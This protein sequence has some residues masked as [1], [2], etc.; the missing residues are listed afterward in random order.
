MNQTLN[1]ICRQLRL[2]YVNE[3]VAEK[4]SV[5]LEALVREVL[6][7]ELAG[8]QRAKLH[9]LLK[10][11]SFPQFKTFDDYSFDTVVFPADYGKERLLRLDWLKQKEN[12]LML[13]AV[14]TGK[15][16]LAIALGIEAA[17][18]GKLVRFFRVADLVNALQLKHDDGTL[19]KF[20]RGLAKADLII[21]DEL[22]YVPFHRTGSELLFNIVTACYEHQS[23][24]VTS[25]L[26]FSQWCTIFGDAKLT[27]ALVDRLVHHAR[28]LAFSGES[29]RLRHALGNIGC[30]QA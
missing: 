1:D 11:A 29:Y 3:A 27:A 23:V 14:G 13:G 26:E 6:Q 10:T 7:A 8:R 12:I 22:G 15:T 19:I 25:N 9:R 17:R 16:H 4:A 18:R 28:I 20:H 21:L 2:A 5:E 30:S 24:I